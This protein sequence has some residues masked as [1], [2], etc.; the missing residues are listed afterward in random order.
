M[1]IS[2]Y[3]GLLL[4]MMNFGIWCRWILLWI[5]RRV[6][7]FQNGILSSQY[8]QKTS[9]ECTIW[10]TSEQAF[11]SCLRPAIGIICILFGQDRNCTDREIQRKNSIISCRK[12]CSRSMIRPDDRDMKSGIIVRGITPLVLAVYLKEEKYLG[13]SVFNKLYRDYFSGQDQR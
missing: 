5:R 4:W 8:S 11:I 2:L 6:T 1:L 9:T 12:T 3:H 10:S 13:T 7:S